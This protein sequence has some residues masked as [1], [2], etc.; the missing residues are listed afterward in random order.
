MFSFDIISFLGNSLISSDY[1]IFLTDESPVFI[2][3]LS[4]FPD[5]HYQLILLNVNT[6]GIYTF[7][8]YS[9][10]NVYGYLYR[11]HFDPENPSSNLLMSDGG[12]LSSSSFKISAYLSAFNI[13]YLVVTTYLPNVTAVATLSVSG[14]RLIDFKLMFSKQP[15]CKIYAHIDSIL[16]F[17]FSEFF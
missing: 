16:F 1:S 10:T 7:N 4:T 5:F 14:P 17:R 3:H 13:Y 11:A 6:P 12:V 9:E 8:C 15:R 2:R